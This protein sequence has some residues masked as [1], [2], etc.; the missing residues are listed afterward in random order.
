MRLS[1]NFD[2]ALLTASTTAIERGIDNSAD[3]AH[4]ANLKRLAE[5]LEKVRALLGQPLAVSS[6]YRSPALNTAVGGVP[7]SRHALGLA[8][9]FTCAGFG[10]PLTVARAIAAS[11]LAYDQVIHEFGRW[12]HLGL[13]REGEAPRRQTLTICTAAQGYVDGLVDCALVA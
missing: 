9:D 10:P 5:A 13:A 4:L 1:R 3:P 12:V 2:L 7:H 6:A 11:E 8:V